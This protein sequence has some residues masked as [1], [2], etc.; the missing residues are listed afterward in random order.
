MPVGI[1]VDLLHRAELFL[2]LRNLHL[3]QLARC[4]LEFHVDRKV[5]ASHLH[6]LAL[7]ATIA[8]T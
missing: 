1:G 6:K 4:F 8:Y 5:V 7:A 3:T 2:V